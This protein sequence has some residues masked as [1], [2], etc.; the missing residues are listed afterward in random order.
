[1][2]FILDYPLFVL[3]LSLMGLYLSEWFGVFF[4]KRRP[5][6]DIDREDF[7]LILASTLTLLG[8][9]IGFTFSMA[10]SRYDQRKNFEAAE[11]N[12]IGTEYLRA[13]LL[14]AAD[15]AKVRTLLENYLGQRVLFYETR[16]AHQLR[17]IDGATARLQTD[18]WSAVRAPAVRQPTVLF[19]I[20]LSGMNEVLDLQGYVQAAWW[21]RIPAAAWGLMI[22]N[23]L[24]CNF[25]MGYGMHRAETKNMLLLLLPIVISISFFLI[26]DIDSPSGG[27]IRVHPQNLERLSQSLRAH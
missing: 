16:D 11:A 20:A 8:L 23:S 19:P 24:L 25:L 27:I 22:A 6:L 18:L 15:A 1:M 3:A 26:A 10:I 17:L 12:A 14:P 7:S 9:I 21:N 5:I 4:H 2:N 13:D